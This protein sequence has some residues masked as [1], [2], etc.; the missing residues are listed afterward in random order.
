MAFVRNLM[1][2]ILRTLK[3]LGFALMRP[4]ALEMRMSFLSVVLPQQPCRE[5]LPLARPWKILLAH[6]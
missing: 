5:R 1:I 4:A 2:H 3:G 6:I